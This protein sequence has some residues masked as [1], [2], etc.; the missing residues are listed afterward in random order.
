MLHLVN[1]TTRARSDAAPPGDIDDYL[2]DA[3]STAVSGAVDRVAASVVHLEVALGDPPRNRGRGR[4]RGRSGATGSGFVFTPDGFLLTNSHVVDR[5]RRV[6]A[7]F[8]DGSRCEA[9]LVGAD[10][11][12]DLAVLRVSAPALAAAAFG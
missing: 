10:P 9:E 12:T 4:D 1:G 3:Y 8:A 2:L 5:A 11:D 7:M 6:R